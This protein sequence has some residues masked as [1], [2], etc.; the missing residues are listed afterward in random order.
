MINLDNRSGKPIYKQIV[1][2][3]IDLIFLGVYPTDSPL[4]SVR[5]LAVELGINPNTIQ[6]AYQELESMGITYA[7]AGKGIFVNS[8]TDVITKR[9]SELRQQ[10]L[11]VLHEARLAGI[12]LNEV[13]SAAK[14]EYREVTNND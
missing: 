5:S 12:S 2:S 14:Y 8:T 6:K 7:V 4:P 10:L 13:L 3:M 11:V 9:Q 1:D